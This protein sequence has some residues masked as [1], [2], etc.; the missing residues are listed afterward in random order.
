M[1][2]QKKTII[3]LLVLGCLFPLWARGCAIYNIELLAHQIY[4]ASIGIGEPVPW[5]SYYGWAAMLIVA[6]ICCSFF[7]HKRWAE[8][9]GRRWTWGF[10]GLLVPWS[11]L[12]IALLKPKVKP[13]LPDLPSCPYCNSKRVKLADPTTPGATL[14]EEQL[15]DFEEGHSVFLECQECY[16]VFKR[17]DSVAIE[18]NMGL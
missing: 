15:A 12:V 9:K 10:L 4:L 5:Y 2:K 17:E 16:A 13:I 11:I 18:A 6:G 7:G 3:T 14:T 8:E 1:G